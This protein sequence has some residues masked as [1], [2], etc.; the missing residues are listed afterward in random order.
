MVSGIIMASGFSRRM[1]QCKLLM[2]YG[3][4]PIID[5]IMDKVV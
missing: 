2:N 3:D 4:R 5:I 1:G